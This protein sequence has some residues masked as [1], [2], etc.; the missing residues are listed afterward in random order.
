[1]DN[2]QKMLQTI[3][4]GQVAFRKE[5]LKRFEGVDKKLDELETKLG[6]RIDKVEEGLN[7]KIDDVE[8]RLENKIDSVEKNLTSRIDQI[9]KQLA[10]L[11]DDAPTRQEFDDLKIKVDKVVQSSSSNL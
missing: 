4:K 2:I 8:L 3:I 9:G 10:Y 1:M 7:R 11:E 6:R 5:I